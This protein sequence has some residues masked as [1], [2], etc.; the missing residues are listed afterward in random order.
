[1]EAGRLLNVDGGVD[2]SVEEGRF[3]VDLLHGVS[4]VSSDGIKNASGF[5]SADRGVCFV[6][7]DVGTLAE[8][9]DDNAGFVSDDFS[10][11]GIDFLDEYPFH[12]DRRVVGIAIDGFECTCGVHYCEFRVTSG[13]PPC[14]VWG[15]EGFLKCLR[16]WKM[17]GVE[18]RYRCG[19][20]IW[21]CSGGGEV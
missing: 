16:V 13:Y 11:V 3:E 8:T 18:V 9:F 15:C 10:R 7:V 1:M 21:H 4:M 19:G 2:F 20:S 12:G 14:G 5:R 6:V 17:R